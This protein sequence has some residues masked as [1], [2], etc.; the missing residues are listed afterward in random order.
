MNEDNDESTA[1]GA[2]AG[3]G[4]PPRNTIYRKVTRGKRRLTRARLLLYRIAVVLA[5]WMI[6]ALWASCRITHVV[7]LEGARQAVRDSKSLIPVY[8]HQH[9]LFAG[10]AVLDLRGDGLKPGFLI[11]PSVDGA[12]PAMLVE[13]VGGVVIRGSSTHT[14]ARALRDFYETIVRQQVSPAITPDGPKG[15][16]HEFKPGAIMLSQITGKPILPIAVAASSKYTFRTWDA[17]EL[18]LPFSRIAIVYGEPVKVPRAADSAALEQRQQ[19]MAALLLAL[20]RE[21]EQAL[22]Q[23]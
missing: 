23:G 8:W 9:M 5:W 19:E 18:P 14:G 2:G 16:L 12:A 15:P 6:R 13:K 3:A 20:R 7:G 1:E 11:S 10:R 21:A 17:F 22:H 4:E